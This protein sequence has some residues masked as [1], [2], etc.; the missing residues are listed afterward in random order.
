MPRE[1]VSNCPHCKG[2]GADP[3]DEGDWVPEVQMYNPFSA[4]P[5]PECNGT[6]EAP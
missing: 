4:G 1:E 2:S 5:C 6:G 3:E